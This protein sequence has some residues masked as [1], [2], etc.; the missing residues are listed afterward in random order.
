MNVP[1]GLRS[2]ARTEP[3][4]GLTAPGG[5]QA[6]VQLVEY[7]SVDRLQTRATDGR[8]Y[9]VAN[10]LGDVD[11]EALR[12]VFAGQDPTSGVALV[13]SKNRTVAAFNLT[14]KADKTVSLLHAFAQPDIAATVEAAQSAAVAASLRYVEDAAV[15]SRRGRN[16]VEQVQGGGMVAAAFRHYRNRNEEP[17]LHDYVLV[18]NMTPGPDGRWSTLDARHLYNHAKTAGYVYQ[19]VMRDELATKL[20]IEFGP[21]VNGVAPIAGIPRPLVDAFSTRRAE[22]LEHLDTV[23]ASSARAAQYAALQTRHGKDQQPDLDLVAAEWQQRARTFGFD[24]ATVEQRVGPSTGRELTRPEQQMHI[25]KMMSPDGHTAHAAMFDRRDVVRSWCEAHRQ[26]APLSEL[27]LLTAHTMRHPDLVPLNAGRWPTQ[28]LLDHE[29]GI[30]DTATKTLGTGIAIATPAAV[31]AAIAAR[32]TITDEQAALVRDLVSR[33]DGV[34]V[35]IAAAGTGKEFVLGVAREAWQA[36]GHRVLGATLAARAAS[37]LRSGAGVGA[38]TITSLIGQLDE[39]KTLKAGDVLVIDEA[40]VVGTRQ[41]SRL[42]SHAADKHAKVVLVGDPRQLPEIHAGGV[43]GGLA[44]HVPVLTLN[45]NR[46]QRQQWERTALRDLRNGSVE[47][48][49]DAYDTHGRIERVPT[50]HDVWARIVDNWAES[51]ANGEESIMLAARRDDVRAL[52]FLARERIGPTRLTGPTLMVDDMQFRAGDQIMTLRNNRRL[53]VHNG[54]RRIIT[55]IDTRSRSIIATMG[56]RTVTL[57]ADYIEAGHVA[58]GYAMTVHKAQGVTVDRAFVLGT[59]DLYREMGYVAMSRGRNGNHLYVVGEPTRETEPLHAPSLERDAEALLV[60]ALSTSRAQT[61]ASAEINPLADT[62]DRELAAEYRELSVWIKAIPPDQCHAIEQMNTRIAGCR[63]TIAT[64]ETRHAHERTIRRSAKDVLAR[65]D[66]RGQ[67]TEQNIARHTTFLGDL[68]RQRASAELIA[69]ERTARLKHEPEV[70]TR[71]TA[72]DNEIG[73]RVELSVDELVAAPSAYI[74][75]ALGARPDDDRLETWTNGVS[76]IER[77]R[78][79]H[80]IDDEKY[81]LGRTD[82]YEARSLS[83]ELQAIHHEIDP[84]AVSRGIDMRM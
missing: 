82:D 5:Q 7:R 50:R 1:D 53:D 16:G 22:I 81:A 11:P 20:G 41:L 23:G 38:Q 33:G 56:E 17:H 30:I 73:R 15:F 24:P 36:D 51:V 61:M 60:S 70:R 34:S 26:G 44:R 32:P 52:N 3:S 12:A 63:T 14:F 27:Q 43:L 46:R 71:L 65:R 67:G 48:A 25:D 54:E 74:E 55:R 58:H 49:L 69:Q 10:Q 9:V 42:I 64:L 47:Q 80:H 45:E 75:R 4:T 62:P 28:D 76:L 8:H 13:A 77:F 21:V 35:L 68:E 83:R 66:D 37:E 59:D 57:P 31:E 18:A 40:G 78:F 2:Q 72:L 39:G 6:G 79:E 84:P 29:Q 19:L